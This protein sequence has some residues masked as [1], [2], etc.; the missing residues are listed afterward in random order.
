M[1]GNWAVGLLIVVFIVIAGYLF[2]DSLD[3]SDIELAEYYDM[4]LVTFEKNG[5]WIT[6]EGLKG[7]KDD[8]IS[9]NLTWGKDA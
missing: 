8:R 3:T 2:E 1:N 5:N 7:T 9:L 6:H 4:P